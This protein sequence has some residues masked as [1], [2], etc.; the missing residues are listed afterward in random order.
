MKKQFKKEFK[1]KLYWHGS[2]GAEP[3]E[4]VQENEMILYVDTDKPYSAFIDWDIPTLG[5]GESIGLSFGRNE[6]GNL[7]LTGY[8]GVM[9]IP[10]EAIELVKEA[11]YMI[12]KDL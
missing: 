4:G 7:E 3:I 6:V 11:G 10:D 1:S 12:S 5:T 2:W 8:D 9:S